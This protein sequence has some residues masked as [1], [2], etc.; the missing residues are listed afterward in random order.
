MTN[1]EKYKDIIID[2]L[3]EYGADIGV[4]NG[5]PVNCRSISCDECD[6][7]RISEKCK[8]ATIEWYLEEYKEKH[9]E[10]HKTAHWEYE[11]YPRV[12]KCSACGRCE[13]LPK[14]DMDDEKI[15]ELFPYC[16]CGA[17]MV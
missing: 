8:R 11:G 3:E 6:L 9:K 12:V 1:L 7:G 14:D 10:K 16:H 2:I 13:V 15:I 5:V 17:E 4:R